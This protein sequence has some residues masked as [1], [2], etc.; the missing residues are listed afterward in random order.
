MSEREELCK[1]LKTLQETMIKR[2]VIA[3]RRAPD[4]FL[5]EIDALET[6]IDLRKKICERKGV[7]DQP[8]FFQNF[9]GVL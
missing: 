3:A 7:T 6:I 4:E 1:I 2:A 9:S 8:R 5:N